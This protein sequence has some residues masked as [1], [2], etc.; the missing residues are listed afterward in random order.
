MQG[1]LLRAIW[2]VRLAT[3]IARQDE[4][5]RAKLEPFLW[6]LFTMLL[7]IGFLESR[8]PSKSLRRF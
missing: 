6:L 2:L 3:L 1:A 8:L 4:L 5:S 7:L